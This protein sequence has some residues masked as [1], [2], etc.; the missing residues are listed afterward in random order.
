MVGVGFSCPAFGWFAPTFDDPRR[1]MVSNYLLPFLTFFGNFAIGRHVWAPVWTLDHLWSIALEEQFYILW[2]PLL[3]LLLR[4]PRRYVWGVLLLLFA[5]T[6]ATRVYL[7]G[8]SS[9]PMLWTNTASRLDPLLAGIA[10]AFYRQAR[11]ALRKGIWG[12]V[13]F[14]VG[15]AVAGSIALGPNIQSN[16]SHQVWQFTATALGFVLAVDAALASGPVAWVFSRRWVAWLGRL[17][18]GL[19]V[20]H[21]LAIQIGG[22]LAGNL[23]Q[24]LGLQRPVGRLLTVALATLAIAAAAVCAARA[25]LPPL[26]ARFAHVS[27]N[28]RP[29]WAGAGRPM[30]RLRARLNALRPRGRCLCPAQSE[31]TPNASRCRRLEQIALGVRVSL[32][33]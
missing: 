13:E 18:Y 11:P 19:Y 30:R 32:V 17:T 4:S 23:S 33:R 29:V 1:A 27:R 21:I 24:G 31:G 22:K 25:V 15:C 10:L 12:G 2:P 3:M 26:K 5:G 28:H 7:V 20:Y 14:V 9:F 16:S 8:H 6:V